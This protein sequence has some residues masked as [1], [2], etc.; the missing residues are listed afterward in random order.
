MELDIK[1]LKQKKSTKELLQFGII[2][3]DKCSGPTS[4]KVSEFV[5]KELNLNKTSHFGTLDPKV[6][7]VLPVGL[8]RACKI[9]GYFSGHD[10]AYIG[11]M[12]IHENISKEKLES[13]I[14]N[15]TGKIMQKPPVK[16]NVK[17]EL[18][19]REIK[20]FKVLEF[21]ENEK[22]ILFYVECQAGTYI[23][24]LISD[25]GEKIEGAHMLELRRVKASIF[26]EHDEN[27]PLINLYDFQ[28]AVEEYKKGNDKKLRDM[29]IPAEI[30]TKIYPIVQIKPQFAD[31]MFHGAK[32]I[33]DFLVDKKSLNSL[34][35]GQI[36]CIFSDDNFIEMAKII[37]EGEILARAEF[38][39][40][41]LVN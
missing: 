31:K 15:F 39:L 5:K 10:K 8:N 9:A 25:L 6:T 18:R 27:Y 35:V 19:E 36:I 41:P 38:V 22:D 1:K 24:K 34:Q 12:R 7:G 33:E 23:R 32:L 11:I 29:I 20:K 14:K 16:S 2:N 40:Q 4:F 3:I 26:S 37:N 21:D 28:S 30:I 13:E 17:R